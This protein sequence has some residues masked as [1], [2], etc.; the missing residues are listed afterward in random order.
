MKDVSELTSQRLFLLQMLSGSQTRAG[1]DV[2]E[3]PQ[4][5]LWGGGD[6][7]ETR[8]RETG[9]TER[10]QEGDRFKFPTS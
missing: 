6:K 3:A 7:R 2:Q 10:R 5:G 1:E 4:T 9:R 8:G